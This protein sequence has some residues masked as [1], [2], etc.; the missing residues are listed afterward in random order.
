MTDYPPISPVTA[1]M[2]GVCPRCGQGPLFEG[3]LKIR[4]SCSVCGLD[5]GIIDTG[6]GPA[7]FIMFI[8]G[9]IVVGGALFVEL[10]YQPP[11]WVHAALWLPLTALLVGVMLRPL[12]GVMA[13]QQY[14]QKAAEG[15]LDKDG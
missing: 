11:Y 10:S 14:Y 8:A 15:A 9:F 5:F 7:V 1:G 4:P 3:F 13:A 6:D 2:R 12:K